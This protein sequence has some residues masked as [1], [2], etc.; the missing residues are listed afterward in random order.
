MEPGYVVLVAVAGV[1]LVVA[2]VFAAYNVLFDKDVEL[3]DYED[4]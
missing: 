3:E 4:E 1:G 2:T